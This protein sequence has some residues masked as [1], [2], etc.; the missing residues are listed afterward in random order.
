MP[1]KPKRS[2]SHPGCP[3]L[4]DGRFCKKHEKEYNKNYE[5]YKIDSKTHNNCWN[6]YQINLL[7]DSSKGSRH[8]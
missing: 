8:T 2:C 4:V 6:R 3:E 1:R 7:L 5:K